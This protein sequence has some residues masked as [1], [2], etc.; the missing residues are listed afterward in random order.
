[1]AHRSMCMSCGERS[2]SVRLARMEDGCWARVCDDC[3]PEQKPEP[4]PTGRRARSHLTRV[5]RF[6]G[7]R[8]AGTAS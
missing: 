8:S 7:R 3:R 5:D 2:E 6:A 1:M 4:V